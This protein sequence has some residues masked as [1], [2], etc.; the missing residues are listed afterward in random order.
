M[1]C[2]VA[3]NNFQSTVV[4][5]VA[6][7]VNTAVRINLLSDIMHCSAVMEHVQRIGRPGLSAVGIIS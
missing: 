5:G 3:K 4:P 1:H 2:S 7:N 6:D